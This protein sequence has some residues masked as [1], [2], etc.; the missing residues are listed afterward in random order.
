MEFG[1]EGLG[2]PNKSDQGARANQTAAFS[3]RGAAQ[4]RAP[5]QNYTRGAVHCSGA[6]IA[7][8]KVRYSS[9]PAAI[10]IVVVLSWS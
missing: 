7:G 6:M 9:L 1:G 8:L 5:E 3:G 4:V 10:I 2:H